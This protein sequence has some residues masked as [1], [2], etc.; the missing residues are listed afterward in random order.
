MFRLQGGPVV[1]NFVIDWTDKY[2]SAQSASARWEVSQQ[3]VAELGGCAINTGILECQS[4]SLKWFQ[5]SMRADWME[6]YLGQQ[7]HLIDPF[8]SHLSKS[9]TPIEGLCGEASRDQVGSEEELHLN[10]ELQDAG[11]GY[12]L[13]MS[14]AGDTAGTRKFVTFC[15]SEN[16]SRLKNSE[17]SERILVSATLIAAF[18]DSLELGAAPVY[19]PSVLETPLS[20]RELEVLRHL[21]QGRQNAQTAFEM[22]IAEITVRKHLR[23]ARRKLGARTREEALAKALRAH[24]LDI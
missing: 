10:Q 3:L 2:L 6:H 17:F 14:F 4:Q 23:S 18:Q 15:S 20:E 11:Y 16:A 1:K 22:G 8:V 19:F 21:A 9:A 5:G 12:M 7:Y 24:L 13:G